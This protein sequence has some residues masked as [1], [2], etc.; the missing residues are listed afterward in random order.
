[1]IACILWHETSTQLPRMQHKKEYM[2]KNG[3]KIMEI[4]QRQMCLELH[5]RT[6]LESRT[7]EAGYME[8]STVMI[9]FFRMQCLLVFMYRASENLK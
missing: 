8:V 3:A 2:A 5:S 4:L 7:F 9:Q 6:E 1:M